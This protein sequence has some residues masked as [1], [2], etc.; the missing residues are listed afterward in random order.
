MGMSAQEIEGMVQAAFP[1]GYI[2]LQDLAG[3]N[4]HYS[5]TVT[6]ESFRGKT[7]VQQHKMVFDSLGGHVG[8]KLHARAVIT[9]VPL[10]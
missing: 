5:I 1:K 7:R 3:D 6:D 10:T 4:E 9:K 2:E 8:T